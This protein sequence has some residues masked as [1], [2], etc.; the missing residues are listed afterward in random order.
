MQG[1]SGIEIN[2]RERLT[3]SLELLGD[4]GHDFARSLDIEVTRQSALK[5]ITEY[6]GAGGGALFLLEDDETIL[7]CQSCVDAANI[8]GLMRSPSPPT[9]RRWAR[10]CG[11]SIKA[12]TPFTPSS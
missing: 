9:M 4:M 3:D 5:R 1:D 2:E 11:R 7:N 10:R 12:S 8:T 6:V